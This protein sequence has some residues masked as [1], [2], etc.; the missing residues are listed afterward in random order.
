M[1]VKKYLHRRL[2][3]YSPCR[4][5]LPMLFHT[6]VIQECMISKHSVRTRQNVL[7]SA[8][9]PYSALYWKGNSCEYN[10]P[11][12]QYM[13]TGLIIYLPIP[14]R[15]IKSRCNPSYL[16]C[17]NEKAWR[18]TRCLQKIATRFSRNDTT[19]SWGVNMYARLKKVRLDTT[20]NVHSTSNI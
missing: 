10:C 18:L 16:I 17:N 14:D 11:H 4:F 6:R 15:Y 13:L 8:M 9:R 2:F 5:Y 19:G 7:V 20:K 3:T 1:F 12:V